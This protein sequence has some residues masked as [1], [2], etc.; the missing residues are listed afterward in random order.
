[1][2]SQAAESLFCYPFQL[3][4]TQGSLSSPTGGSHSPTRFRRRQFS[5]S[6]WGAVW[7]KKLIMGYLD[8]LGHLPVYAGIWGRSG[9]QIRQIFVAYLWLPPLWEKKAQHLFLTVTHGHRI[10]WGQ[11]K[12]VL[13][14]QSQLRGWARDGQKG[15]GCCLFFLC[16]WNKSSLSALYKSIADWQLRIYIWVLWR[17]Q[18]TISERV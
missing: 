6:S 9:G 1:M 5:E 3:E 2:C 15:L 8:I 10:Y 18:N 13:P 17:Q 4:Y 14:I 12:E 11:G 7:L 16:C